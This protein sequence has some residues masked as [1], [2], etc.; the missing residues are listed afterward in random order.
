M[1]GWLFIVFSILGVSGTANQSNQGKSINCL[2][3][4]LKLSST[5]SVPP[6]FFH[7]CL[8]PTFFLLSFL[9]FS[10]L[11]PLSLSLSLSFS[12]PPFFFSFF[13]FLPRS[14]SPP[15]LRHHATTRRRHSLTPS[16]SLTRH[17]SPPLFHTLLPSLLLLS[18]LLL[19]DYSPPPLSFLVNTPH[20]TL[21]PLL[22]LHLSLPLHNTHIY[23]QDDTLQAGRSRSKCPSFQQGWTSISWHHFCAI[24]VSHFVFMNNVS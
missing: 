17:P 13:S 19:V 16:P 14:L 9:L 7:H 24:V 5:L 15:S 2:V 10:F 3:L 22:H 23:L 11:I 8:Q 6:P 1:L 21:I 20:P 18:S 12:L 4:S